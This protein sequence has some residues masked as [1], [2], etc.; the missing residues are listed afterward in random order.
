[1]AAAVPETEW[2]LD[3]VLLLALSSYLALY[4][5]RW[6]AARREAGARGASVPRLL[7]FSAGIA[8]LFAALASP[9]DALGERLF[10]MHMVQHILLGDLA[11][12]LLLL[13]LTK[14]ILRPVTARLHRVERALGPLAHPAVAVL[15]YAGTLWL[16]HLPALYELGLRNPALHPVQH[17]AF[18]AAPL[19]FWW[20]LLSPVPGR[21]RPRGMGVVFYIAAGKVLMGVLASVITFA[22][23]FFYDF[24]AEQ[25]DYWGLTPADDQALAGSLMMAEQSIV[26]TAAVVILFVR[27]L[28]DS[29]REQRRAER[30]G[31][32]AAP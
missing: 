29:E 5:V 15:V 21:R 22:P 17:A 31:L 7:S 6:H 1:M 14:V 12:I 23:V 30:F 25:P 24:Y 2:N 28:G 26:F 18:V 19:V 27:M 20:P 4:V 3:P 9:L 16:L 8:C 10:S 13:G 11:A 32:D